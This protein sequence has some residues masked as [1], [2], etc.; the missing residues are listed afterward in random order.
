MRDNFR[1]IRGIE[2][3]TKKKKKLNKK[4]RQKISQM[5]YGRIKDYIKYKA[6]E[7][8]IEVKL[9]KRELYFSDLS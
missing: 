9:V 2:K 5:E 6:E 3:N 8:G 7:Q 1:D 4:N